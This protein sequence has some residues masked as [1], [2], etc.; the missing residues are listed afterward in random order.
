[1]A[2]VGYSSANYHAPIELLVFA[3]VFDGPF[4]ELHRPYWFSIRRVR[5]LLFASPWFRRD[6]FV[7]ATTGNFSYPRRVF[8]TRL[9]FDTVA[10]TNYTCRVRRRYNV[11][12][13]GPA[14][15]CR[16]DQTVFSVLRAVLPISVRVRATRRRK[17]EYP[18]VTI[19]RPPLSRARLFNSPTPAPE[20][21]RLVRTIRSEGRAVEVDYRPYMFNGVFVVAV[22]SRILIIVPYETHRQPLTPEFHL[23]VA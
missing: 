23:N 1:L 6:S 21:T 16:R 10:R 5:C 4:S 20:L 18:R 19:R 7:I 2:A 15:L 14:H 8:Y 13:Y 11:A 3:S 17:F 9:S 22:A 12:L